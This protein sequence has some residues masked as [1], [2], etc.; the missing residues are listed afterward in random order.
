[1][2]TIKIAIIYLLIG[3]IWVI[4]DFR[5]VLHYALMVLRDCFL[6]LLRGEIELFNSKRLQ[7]MRLQDEA[8]FKSPGY[9]AFRDYKAAFLKILFWPFVLLGLIYGYYKHIILIKHYPSWEHLKQF[10]IWM[11]QLSPKQNKMETSQMPNSKPSRDEFGEAI[12][13]ALSPENSRRRLAERAKRIEQIK[14]QEKLGEKLF[15]QL[16]KTKTNKG[17]NNN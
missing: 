3:F 1:M 8:L 12:M 7:T 9:A 11:L 13:K 5:K 14:E 16:S 15:S 2:S 10:I 17:E 4:W 6:L